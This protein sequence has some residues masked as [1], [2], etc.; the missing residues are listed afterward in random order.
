M[1]TPWPSDAAAGHPQSG[2]GTRRSRTLPAASPCIERAAF[3]DLAAL[4]RLEQQCFDASVAISRRQFRYLLTRP[5]AEVWVCRGNGRVIANAVILLRHTSRGVLGR[6]YSLAV[7]PEQ[8]GR[9]IGRRLLRA[10]LHR[11]R[12]RGAYAVVLEVRSDNLPALALYRAERFRAVECIDGY[13]A[14]GCSAVRLRL[15]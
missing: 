15:P 12:R 4:V 2:N 14:G 1:T 10:C 7:E 13:Y 5:T 3:T 11:V 9:G 6:L 8:R